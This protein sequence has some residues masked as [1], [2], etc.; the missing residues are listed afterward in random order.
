[1]ETDVR[2]AK[3]GADQFA[4]VSLRQSPAYG[5]SEAAH[6]LQIPTATL[7]SWVRGRHYPLSGGSTGFFHPVIVLP[8]PKQSLL[9]FINLVEA[10][11]L[12]AIRRKHKIELKK[13]RS[14][15]RYLREQM[16]VE[17]PLAYRQM[18]TDGC[19]LFV[20]RYAELINVSQEGQLGM[21]DIL[22]AYLRRVEWD[23]TGLALRLYPFTRKKEL[24]EPKFIV[25]DPYV[26]FGKPVLVGTGVPTS[27]VAE[28]YKAGESVDELADDYGLGRTLVEEAIRCELRA[29]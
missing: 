27:V 6:Y 1:M 25:I 8:D 14:T 22:T 28:R 10:H 17:H 15:I 13:V 7:R 9:S 5:I 29:A 26:S 12:D 11:A 23:E 3:D 4:E 24:G 20:K 19:D 16:G 2:M 21:A 18:L